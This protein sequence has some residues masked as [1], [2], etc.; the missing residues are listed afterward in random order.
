VEQLKLVV[1]QL[2]KLVVEVDSLKVDIALTQ[3][4]ARLILFEQLGPTSSTSSSMARVDDYREKAINFYYPNLDVRARPDLRC[5]LTDIEFPYAEVIA[6]HIYRRSWNRAFRKEMGFEINTPGNLLLL[7]GAAEKKFDQFQWT[8]K[9][10]PPQMHEK[11]AVIGLM[12]P[13][14]VLVLNPKLLQGRE[15]H[16]AIHLCTTKWADVHG[17]VLLF[18][19]GEDEPKPMRRVC[20]LH[21]LLAIQHAK[22]EGWLKEAADRAHR[23]SDEDLTV[24]EEAWASP[25]FNRER[26]DV[27]L[28]NPPADSDSD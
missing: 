26:M 3:K 22:E 11:D 10:L 16:I 4:T 15:Q 28:A 8:L 12:Q 13:Y 24:D 21:A 27:F 17:K 5:M 25:T 18:G 7:V 6:A 2:Q 9:P 1:E 14:K 20:G 23:L 19:A